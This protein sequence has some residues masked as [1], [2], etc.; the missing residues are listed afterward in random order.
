MVGLWYSSPTETNEEI[1][2]SQFFEERK[3]YKFVG[4]Y[5]K[6]KFT[7][8][9]AYGLNTAF[10]KY[11]GM[12]PFEVEIDYHNGKPRVS[13]IRV[14]DELMFVDLSKI[15]GNPDDATSVLFNSVGAFAHEFEYFIEVVR[16]LAT[17]S[18][19][20]K[21]EPKP[22]KATADWK[23][24]IV[25]NGKIEVHSRH[26]TKEQADRQAE[27]LLTSSFQQV[28]YIVKGDVTQA[29]TTK[30]LKLETI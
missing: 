28:C 8:N 9:G 13:R 20:V 24:L 21:P 23:V 11:V 15:T 12:N 1:E 22:V 2:M 3:F 25:K 10:A 4:E 17:T 6:N 26:N 7:N 29:T 19:A 27:E 16:P 18:I 30:Q 14:Y 5:T